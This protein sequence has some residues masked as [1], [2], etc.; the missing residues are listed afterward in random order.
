[1]MICVSPEVLRKFVKRTTEAT[2]VGHLLARFKEEA[3][4]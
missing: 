4:L 2:S 1:M 3:T